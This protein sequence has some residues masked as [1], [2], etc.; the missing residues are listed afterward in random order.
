M[1]KKVESINMMH[2]G[3]LDG[4]KILDHALTLI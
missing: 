1:V 2:Y 3:M 4:E